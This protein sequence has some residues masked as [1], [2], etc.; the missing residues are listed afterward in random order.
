MA[1]NKIFNGCVEI[2]RA[3][4]KKDQ[5]LKQV[6]N[7]LAFYKR[8]L[9]EKVKQNTE[10]LFSEREHQFLK[11]STSPDRISLFELIIN[12]CKAGIEKKKV[13]LSFPHSQILVIPREEFNQHGFEYDSKPGKE[14]IVSI[15]KSIATKFNLHS[16]RIAFESFGNGA[17]IFHLDKTKN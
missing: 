14:E 10:T 8:E 9:A 4:I 17:L 1:Q 6:E 3:I 5:K 11:L 2:T 16:R 13:V 15:V 12:R 7:E